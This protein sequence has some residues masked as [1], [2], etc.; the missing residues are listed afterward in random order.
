MLTCCLCIARV[1]GH[2]DDITCSYRLSD[3]V[4]WDGTFQDL[5]HQLTNFS[6][7]LDVVLY[8]SA[9]REDCLKTTEVICNKD[10]VRTTFIQDVT[11][12]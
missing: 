9:A 11:K 10:L 4:L 2:C 8:G 5:N 7:Y 12:L 3:G 1:V 6:D